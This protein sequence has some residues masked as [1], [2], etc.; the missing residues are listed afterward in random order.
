MSTEILERKPQT[1]D[2]YK[3]SFPE[4]FSE[5]IPKSTRLCGLAEIEIE[6]LNEMK[7]DL[8]GHYNTGVEL[9]NNYQNDPTIFH[10]EVGAAQFESLK[11]QNA[12]LDSCIQAVDSIIDEIETANPLPPLPG[13]KTSDDMWLWKRLSDFK[14]LLQE[15]SKSLKI[16]SICVT[17]TGKEYG[18]SSELKSAFDTSTKLFKQLTK[19]FNQFF[20]LGE[21]E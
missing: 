8:I 17:D 9:V 10:P 21:K 18:S 5:E 11:A 12:M 2:D 7:T 3:E 1:L 15:T 19:K 16:D 20:G 13:C 4:H 6:T 14:D